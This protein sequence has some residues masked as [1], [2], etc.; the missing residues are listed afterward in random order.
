MSE[1]VALPKEVAEVI[2]HLRSLPY[3]SDDKIL[4]VT[5]DPADEWVGAKTDALNGVDTMT[6]ASA[7]VNGYTVEQTPHEKLRNYYEAN[8]WLQDSEEMSSTERQRSLGCRQGVRK[9]LH[10]LGIIVE[11]INDTTDAK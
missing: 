9:T 7:L 6:L 2:E 11:G 3:Y 1:K 4:E 10:I 8:D 5:V